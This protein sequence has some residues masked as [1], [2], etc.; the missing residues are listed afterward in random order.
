[1]MKSSRVLVDTDVITMTR[2]K[3]LG[4]RNLQ[5]P[6]T[7]TSYQFEVVHTEKEAAE[8][9]RKAEIL[10]PKFNMMAKMKFDPNKGLGKH[11]Q[12]RK[13][14]IKA[15][16][17]PYKAGLGFKPLLKHQFKKNKKKKAG[18]KIAHSILYQLRTLQDSV[19]P[20][21]LNPPAQTSTIQAQ[22][23]THTNRT[24]HNSTSNH[25]STSYLPS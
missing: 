14:P 18:H 13:N 6:N 4:V 2:P 5:A 15:I 19:I 23:R 17:V 16:R 24:N 7:F 10:P 25:Q 20:C 21:Q 9:K 22:H 11:S 8:L 12:G 3:I 1:M